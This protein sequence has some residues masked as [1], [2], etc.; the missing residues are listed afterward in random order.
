MTEPCSR[1]FGIKM[2]GA[3]QASLGFTII[4]LLVVVVIL[5]LL[6]GLILSSVGAARERWAT[7]VS[8]GRLP[9]LASASAQRLEASDV[10]KILRTSCRPLVRDEMPQRKHVERDATDDARHLFRPGIIETHAIDRGQ[11]ID[12]VRRQS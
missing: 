9:A 3:I 1:R 4:E 6:V 2:P 10:S 11:K 5:G 12:P 8:E 7:R